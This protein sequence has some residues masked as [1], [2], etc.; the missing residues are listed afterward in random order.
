M[1][2]ILGMMMKRFFLDTKFITDKLI[3]YQKFKI[4]SI[5]DSG[6]FL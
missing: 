4:L 6:D 5:T 1:S 3:F 2:Q